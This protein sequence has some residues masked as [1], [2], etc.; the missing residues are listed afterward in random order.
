LSFGF[1]AGLAIALWSAN[2]GIKA[3]FQA[4]NIAHEEQEKRGLVR[5]HLVTFSF[6]IG[7]I[8]IGILFLVSVGVVPAGYDP[9]CRRVCCASNGVP[10]SRDAVR[11]GNLAPSPKRILI[12]RSAKSSPIEA[13]S[14]VNR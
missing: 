3:T 14:T 13:T 6:T 5:L 2:N 1:A 8:L 9:P 12:F 7:S 4:M 10:R 11:M